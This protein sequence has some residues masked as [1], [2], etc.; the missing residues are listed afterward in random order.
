MAAGAATFDQLL[1]RAAA[2]R[3]QGNLT[4]AIDALQAAQALAVGDGQRRQSASALGQ[5]L[6]QARRLEQADAVLHSAY[7]MT[8]GGERARVA[9]ALGN[10]AQLRKQSEAARQ[11]YAEAQRLAAGDTG[12]ALSAALNLARLD[13]PAARQA[14]LAAL[15]ARL[16]QA[17]LPPA[18]HA[19][20]LV[21]LAQLAAQSGE[22]ALAYGSLVLAREQA[23][24]Q[25]RLQAEALDAMAQLYEDQRQ[26]DAALLLTQ[27]AQALADGLPPAAVAD[28]QVALAWRLA[29]ISQARGQLAAALA[30]YQQA[31]DLLERLR[32]DVPIEL[33][34]GRSS[35]RALFEPVYLG[36][37]DVLLQA[38]AAPGQF[39]GQSA[40]QSSDYL[41]RARDAAELIRQSELQDYLGDRCATDSVKGG[42]PTVI[43][44]GTA[45]LYPLM[46]ADRTELLF[47]TADGI[48]RHTSPATGEQ[49][50][51]AAVS[52]AH[53]LRNGSS[54]YASAARQLYDWL[55]RPID[56]A[57]TAAGI[58]T[59][60]VAADGALRLVPI[61]ALHDGS[62]FAIERYAISTVTGLSMTNT[63][64][65]PSGGKASLVAGA[66][67]FGGAVDK[68]LQTSPGRALAAGVARNLALDSAGKGRMLRAPVFDASGG[69]A[70]LVA[71]V[72]EALALPGVGR[73]V[74]A[75]GALLPGTS[76]LD[77]RFSVAAFSQA[78]SSGQY[79]IVHVAS[80]GVFG[81]SA[82][83]SFVLAYDDLLTLDKLQTL[84][85]GEQFRRHPIEL[86]TLSACETAEGN[87]RAPLGIAGAAMKAR[88]KSVLGT[89][90]P[91]DDE[92]AVLVMRHFYR[93]LAQARGGK[94]QALRQAQLALM[95]SPEF[96][97]PL[98]WAPFSLIG[99]W[100]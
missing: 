92:A 47:E 88:A 45:V 52:L 32:P 66:A 1:A 37:A 50:R 87:D 68:L 12:L 14:S 98:F 73:E 64:V 27:Q 26:P 75:V 40:A 36:L 21:N 30:F 62:R 3:E 65:P 6:L 38:A 67:T 29:R 10:L 53:A 94:S 99:N 83:A 22:L 54:H 24:P 11:A 63:S 25:S 2:D 8:Q 60:V 23:P 70:N 57:A 96:A 31:A 39:A 93:E 18:Q 46:F 49:V 56:A 44:V 61:G 41:R 20:L 89:L 80:H 86:L 91:V 79:Q 55:L 77:E 16:D 71:R 95:R 76:L 42:S 7:T 90:W 34:D 69:D 72:R 5:A 78:A 100:L 35:F 48:T 82:G 33:D 74:D 84:L 43:P 97:H 9:L 19:T 59:L 51:A 28:L 17:A 15:R 81:G 58:D 85:S 4:L 13:A